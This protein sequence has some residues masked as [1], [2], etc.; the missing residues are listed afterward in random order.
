M[1]DEQF[2]RQALALADRAAAVG[3]IPIGAIVVCDGKVV[4]SGYNLRE[5]IPDATAHA[6]MIA[7]QEACKN[8]QRWRLSDCTL[9][10]TIEPCPNE[11]AAVLRCHETKIDLILTVMVKYFY[12][13]VQMR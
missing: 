11:S 6:E 5:S 7:L 10:V 3:E 1:S 8:L 4:G 12:R 13:L 2:M 9:Y